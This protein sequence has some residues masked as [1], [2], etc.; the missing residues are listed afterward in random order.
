MSLFAWC[1]ADVRGWLYGYDTCVSVDHKC[2]GVASASLRQSA[3]MSTLVSHVA[4]VRHWFR[5]L[6]LFVLFYEGYVTFVWIVVKI[7]SDLHQKE[8]TAWLINMVCCNIWSINLDFI[9][10]QIYIW[11]PVLILQLVFI[12]L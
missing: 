3:W 8:K 12:D 4:V 9:I 1:V 6:S 2:C 10:M 7:L 5:L 11:S